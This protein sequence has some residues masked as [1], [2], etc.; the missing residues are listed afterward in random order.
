MTAVTIVINSVMK[1][2]VRK[3][4]NRLQRR[5]VNLEL[6]PLWEMAAHYHLKSTLHRKGH[7]IRQECPAG[8]PATITHFFHLAIDCSARMAVF[9]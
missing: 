1:L 5:L 6:I 8:R 3:G 4:E 9:A 7:L 2:Y